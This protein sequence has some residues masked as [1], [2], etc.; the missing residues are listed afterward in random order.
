MASNRD[1]R[2]RYKKPKLNVCRRKPDLPIEIEHNYSS[3]HMCL[4]DGCNNKNCP[5]VNEKVARDGW[6]QGRR[7]VEFDI[8]LSNL[9]SCKFCLL[10]PIPLTYYNVVDEMQRGLGGYLYVRCQ[11]EHCGKVN[12]V[13]YGSTYHEHNKTGMPCF[14]VNTKLGTGMFVDITEFL[15][16]YCFDQVIT[17]QSRHNRTSTF[18]VYI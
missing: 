1:A 3:G 11:N 8:L 10:G 12:N 6:K 18:Y 15:C 16:Y 13:A 17:S 2:G 7:I 14:T 5:F 4:G 9:K